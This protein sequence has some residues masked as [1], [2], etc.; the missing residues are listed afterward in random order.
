MTRAIVAAIA[1]EDLGRHHQTPGGP[2]L[3]LYHQMGLT[4][5]DSSEAPCELVHVQPL[6]WRGRGFCTNRP[7]RYMYHLGSKTPLA[8]LPRLYHSFLFLGGGTG[9]SAAL[10]PNLRGFL[11]ILAHG[12]ERLCTSYV[13]VQVAVQADLIRSISFSPD[14]VSRDSP[15]EP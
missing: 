2:V 6:E 5:H 3:I 7:Q 11:G 8:C 15:D 10:V 12:T 13:V 9:T 1:D 4:L 14:L